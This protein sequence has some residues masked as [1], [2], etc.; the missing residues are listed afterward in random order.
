MTPATSGSKRLRELAYASQPPGLFHGKK[1]AHAL[2]RSAGQDGQVGAAPWAHATVGK[3][4]A[5][6]QYDV[7]E[8]AVGL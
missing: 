3:D 7:E 2:E 6:P 4:N 1:L 8:D 5:A